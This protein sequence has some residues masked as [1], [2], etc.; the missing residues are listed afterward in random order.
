MFLF[1]LELEFAYDM[2]FEYLELTFACVSFG[3]VTNRLVF[4]SSTVPILGAL[5]GSRTDGSNTDLRDR[6]SIRA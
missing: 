4:M 3:L 2:D 6:V 1:L 5:H